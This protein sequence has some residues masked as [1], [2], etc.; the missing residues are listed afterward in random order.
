MSEAQGKWKGLVVSV[1]LAGNSIAW[2]NQD[3]TSKSAAAAIITATS[4]ARD[5]VGRNISRQKS[6]QGSGID[7]KLRTVLQTER[8]YFDYGMDQGLVS[9]NGTIVGFNKKFGVLVVF[10]PK[11]EA[12]AVVWICKVLPIE[13]TPSPLCK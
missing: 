8:G 3:V 10:E 7:V 1:L 5:E 2:A 11:L 13:S 6:I 12:G 4:L 9:T